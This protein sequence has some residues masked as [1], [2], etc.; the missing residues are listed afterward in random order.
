MKCFHMNEDSGRIYKAIAGIAFEEGY[1]EAKKQEW[2]GDLYTC[3][4]LDPP[5]RRRQNKIVSTRDLLG[6]TFVR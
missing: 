6:K 1:W 3:I 4:Y 5:G 2:E